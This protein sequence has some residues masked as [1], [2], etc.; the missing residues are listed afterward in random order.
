MFILFYHP[1]ITEVL[2]AYIALYVVM[3][4]RARWWKALCLTIWQLYD[5]AAYL[6]HS[7]L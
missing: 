1:K 3:R 6:F 4:S 5:H 2:S 7:S